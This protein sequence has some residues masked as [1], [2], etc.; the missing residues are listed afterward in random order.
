MPGLGIFMTW[1]LPA[2][3]GTEM[4]TIQNFLLISLKLPPPVLGGE[5]PK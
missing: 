1:A 4:G 3:E 2:T 5:T